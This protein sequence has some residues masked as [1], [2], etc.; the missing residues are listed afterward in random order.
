MLYQFKC[1]ACGH[2]Q[3]AVFAMTDYDKK[4][5][6]DGRLKRKKCKKCNTISLY[7]HIIRAPGVLGGTNGYVSM[8]RW[9]KQN[10]DHSKRKQAELDKKMGN[11]HRKRVLDKINKGMKQRG[12]DERHKDYGD[13]Q[14][15]SNL[16][17]ADD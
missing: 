8:E 2:E 1:R 6:E 15:E 16:G 9:L 12:R 7:R 3:T 5:K 14:S 11:R 17:S 4:V 13:G 10:P